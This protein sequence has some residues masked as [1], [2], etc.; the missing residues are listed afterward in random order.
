MATATTTD[1]N[2]LYASVFGTTPSANSS[3]SGAPSGSADWASALSGSRSPA[4][5]APGATSPTPPTPQASPAAP[6]SPSASPSAPAPSY[7]TS[8]DVGTPA[9]QT[10][11][12]N[13]APSA[14]AATTVPFSAASPAGAPAQASAPGF[15]VTAPTYTPGAVPMD[16][17]NF[18]Y[19]QILGD[20][21]VN[22]PT[23]AAN[24]KLTQDI[25]ANPE[26]MSPQVVAQM[27]AAN[28]DQ[29]AEQQAQ[30]DQAAKEMGA[31]YGITDSPWLA[32]QRLA[33][34]RSANQAIVAGNRNIE[35]TAAQTNFAN[36]L[37]AAQTGQAAVQQKTAAKQAAVQ[38]ASNTALQSAAAQGDRM[39]LREQI[40][41]A[42]TQLGLSSDQLML[43]YTLGKLADATQR[44][45]QQL[46]FEEAEKQ[47]EQGGRQ[48]QEDLA[49][50]LAQ[51][52]T[53]NQQFGAQYG[54]D[55]INAQTGANNSAYS[56][57]ANTFGG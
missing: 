28:K 10:V 35:T 27:E 34:Q 38:L 50:K 21:T 16:V 33:G 7:A 2:S 25:L 22:D 49:F 24:D 6:A 9:P 11:P 32:S 42:A 53:Q 3:Q 36:K 55:L 1:P 19:D 47:L 48:F 26:S 56:Q 54:I 17:P 46:N 13:S 15:Q 43:Q 4:S 20:A 23:T 5:S 29:I 31:S 40:N 52:D 12:F 44:N 37:A 14:P 30:E 45:G 51:L 39:A 8:G 41:Q 57:Y 18:S